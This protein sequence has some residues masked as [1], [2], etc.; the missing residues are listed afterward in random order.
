M[1]GVNL[2]FAIGDNTHG[3]NQGVPLTASLSVEFSDLKTE[4]GDVFQSAK[5][6]L[7]NSFDLIY[8]DPLRLQTVSDLETNNV[9]VWETPQQAAAQKGTGYSMEREFAVQLAGSVYTIG[10]W[11]GQS[12][13]QAVC[14]QYTSQQNCYDVGT[15]YA[16]CGSVFCDTTNSSASVTA[17]IASKYSS[18]LPASVYNT[19]LVVPSVS[20]VACDG[21][22]NAAPFENFFGALNPTVNPATATQPINLG[23]YKS[24]YFL[25]DHGNSSVQVNQTCSN[26]HPD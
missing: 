23:I 8:S 7:A 10:E 24:Y 15:R 9:I 16:H 21:N 5:S 2:G 25:Y 20:N 6:A 13:L 22:G 4:A 19:F 18:S 3:A 12:N 26:N 14:T 17:S 1:S 11:S